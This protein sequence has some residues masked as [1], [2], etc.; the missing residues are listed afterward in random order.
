MNQL[1]IDAAEWIELARKL[2]ELEAQATKTYNMAQIADTAV[3][4]TT[5]IIEKQKDDIQENEKKIELTRNKAFTTFSYVT[6]LGNIASS[7]VQQSFEGTEAALGAQ[8]ASQLIQIGST[9]LAISR[10]VALSIADPA[11]APLYLTLA[12][13]MQYNLIQQQQLQ[14]QTSEVQRRQK[15]V[16][17]SYQRWS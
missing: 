17:E 3:K 16:M 11:I 12:A 15:E 2:A 10:M 7:I 8:K 5:P 9:E 13:S 14:Y 6:H 4:K 1:D